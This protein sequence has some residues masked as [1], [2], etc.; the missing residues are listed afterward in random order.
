MTAASSSAFSWAELDEILRGTGRDGT[1]GMSAVDGLIAALA[2]APSF[3][4]P[5]EWIPLIFG[6]RRPEASEGSVGLRA[7]RTIFNR[8]NEVS[9]VLSQAPATYQPIF[10][11]APDGT[12]VVGD[13]AAGFMVGMALRPDSWRSAIL[14][15]PNRKLMAPILAC[16]ELGAELLTDIP[17]VERRRIAATAHRDIGPAVA[18]IRAVCNPHRAAEMQAPPARS[19]RRPRKRQVARSR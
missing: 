17:A 11:V 12:T 2:A 7:V 3:V 5:D 16:S 19:P 4:H 15:T 9:E 18:A 6:G 13:W 10:M 8:Y 1:I 14:G